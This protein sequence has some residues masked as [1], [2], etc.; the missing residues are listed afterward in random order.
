M[1]AISADMVFLKD[2][3]PFRNPHLD[4]Q[5]LSDWHL[6]IVPTA[7]VRVLFLDCFKPSTRCSIHQSPSLGVTLCESMNAI[8]LL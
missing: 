6:S 7:K 4:M 1:S 8:I 2:P 3:L 5:G